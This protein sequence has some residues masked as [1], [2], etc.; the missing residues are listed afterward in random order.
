VLVP[1]RLPCRSGTTLA[2]PGIVHG[3]SRIPFCHRR[4]RSRRTH[5]RQVADDGA[6]Q[7]ARGWDRRRRRGGSAGCDPAR[8]VVAA[9][10]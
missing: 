8:T 6:G 4:N 3:A 10:T 5:I 9:V 1:L 7:C 2:A